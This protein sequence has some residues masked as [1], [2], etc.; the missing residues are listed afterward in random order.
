[1]ITSTWIAPRKQLEINAAHAA[2][3][4]L[5][6]TVGHSKVCMLLNSGPAGPKIIRLCLG[7]CVLL[8]NFQSN[9]VGDWFFF[10]RILTGI[11]TG[12]GCLIF[13]AVFLKFHSK[14]SRSKRKPRIWQW[15]YMINLVEAQTQLVRLWEKVEYQ[16]GHNETWRKKEK[17]R[18][19]KN[20]DCRYL[21]LSW[22]YNDVLFLK[23]VALIQW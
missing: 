21:S 4:L 15:L 7:F 22:S 12:T 10:C 6:W 23:N 20:H 11:V 8:W 2:V 14:G 1:M 3:V 5:G 13:R 19:Y 16:N 9:N 17:K 18:G